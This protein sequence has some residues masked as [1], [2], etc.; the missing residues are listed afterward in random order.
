M[1]NATSTMP[2]G[3]LHPHSGGPARG[4]RGHGREGSS[5]GVQETS[6]GRRLCHDQWSGRGGERL[7]CIQKGTGR[8]LTMKLKIVSSKENPG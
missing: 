6:Q 8:L 1:R 4:P 7:P 2:T 3:D 5:H